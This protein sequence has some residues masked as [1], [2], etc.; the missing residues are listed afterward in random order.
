MIAVASVDHCTN[1]GSE[2]HAEN[3]FG[4]LN[5]IRIACTS[6][7]E[8]IGLKNFLVP[9]NIKLSMAGCVGIPEYAAALKANMKK[10]GI[11]FTESGHRL[12]YIRTVGTFA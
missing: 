4:K 12:H 7:L 6:N 2:K 3:M 8:T 10:D 1:I 9:D 5:A 11:H